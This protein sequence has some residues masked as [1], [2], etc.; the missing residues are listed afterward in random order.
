MPYKNKEYAIKHR[1]EYYLK[2]RIKL[3]DKNKKYRINNY[4]Q[5]SKRNTLSR[6]KSRT[7]IIISMEDY[8][9]L[10]IFNKCNICG[11]KPQN[12][13]LA[14]D[15]DHKTNKIRGLLCG[16]C[17]R[18]LGCFYDNK[19]LLKNAIIYLNEKTK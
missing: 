16:Q 14:I 6:I 19:K 4:E 9:K 8:D 12:K 3:I 17:N 5:V 18:G 15:H 13:R 2:N 1:K 7:G 10:L 11:K